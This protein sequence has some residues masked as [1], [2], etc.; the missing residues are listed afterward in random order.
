MQYRAI[1]AEAWELTHAERGLLPFGTIPAFFAVLVGVGFV[2]YQYILFQ[3]S[4]FFGHADLS[5]LSSL[6]DPALAFFQSHGGLLALAIIFILITAAGFLLLP[7]L[8]DSSLIAL[9]A[10][11]KQGKET[12]TRAG[13]VAGMS[14]F[15]PMFEL[16]AV[17]AV[18]SFAELLT[19]L[20]M[21]LRI[22]G[23]S[24]GLFIFF[25]VLAFL[26]L[27]VYLLF[28]YAEQFLVLR[29][30]GVMESLA[31]SASLVVSSIDHTFFILSLLLLIFIRSLINVVLLFLIPGL[32]IFIA[33]LFVG[34]LAFMVALIFA[35]LLGFL[36]LLLT[37]YLM[38]TLH[39]FTKAAWTL[40]FLHLEAERAR[41]AAL[42][43]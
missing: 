11:I 3:T 26:S 21:A 28:T 34:Q 17:T 19:I 15:L 43:E 32:I 37:A 7:A 16:R 39:V 40:T 23:P 27:T 33:G 2:L 25:G 30:K 10:G 38:G 6:I 20:L 29:G 35:S 31:A 13:L 42:L 24:S 1:I 8:T 36:V 41:A 18:F 14:R 5:W 4:P 12:S 22:F 9:V